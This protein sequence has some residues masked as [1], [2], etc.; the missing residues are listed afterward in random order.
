MKKYTFYIP[1]YIPHYRKIKAKNE[2]NAVWKFLQTI[3]LREDIYWE[4][5]NE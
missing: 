2:A 5:V 1:Y 4:I 3:K